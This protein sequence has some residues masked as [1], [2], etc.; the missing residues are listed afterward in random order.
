MVCL[1][2]GRSERVQI[3]WGV[4]E[5][6]EEADDAARVLFIVSSFCASRAEG[7]YY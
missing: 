7:F 5:T 1:G 3:Y 2:S 4:R 6:M